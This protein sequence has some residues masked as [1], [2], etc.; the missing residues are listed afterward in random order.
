[1]KPP[2][3]AAGNLLTPELLAGGGDYIEGLM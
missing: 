1:M 2:V 3:V